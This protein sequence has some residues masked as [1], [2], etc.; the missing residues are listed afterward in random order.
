MRIDLPNS[1]EFKE[2][3][4][5]L[6]K[7]TIEYKISGISTDSRNIKENDLYIAI[8]GEKFD[9]NDFTKDALN[10]GASFAIVHQLQ[11]EKIERQLLSLNPIGLIS[12]LLHYG[13]KDL[14][15]QL[16]ELLVQM[17]KHLQKSSLSIFY[18]LNLIFMRQKKTLIL[19][20]VCHLHYYK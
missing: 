18:Q 20:L 11:N 15:Y 16:L 19:Q 14:T 10:R 9:G 7:K 2:I 1:N 8:K 17:A 5:T 13:E 6:T 12:E 3:F 4:C